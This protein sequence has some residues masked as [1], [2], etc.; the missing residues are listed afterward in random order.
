MTKIT[1]NYF[2]SQMKID[3]FDFDNYSRED[4]LTYEEWLSVFLRWI[5]QDKLADNAS[6]VTKQYKTTTIQSEVNLD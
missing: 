2:I 3:L 5:G 1:Q 4:L 6:L